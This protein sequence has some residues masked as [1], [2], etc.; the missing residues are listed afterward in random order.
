MPMRMRLEGSRK[1]GRSLPY[2]LV[3]PEV[4][5][6][7]CRAP[8]PSS[9]QPGSRSTCLEVTQQQEGVDVLAV[10]VVWEDEGPEFRHASSVALTSHLGAR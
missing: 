3:H 1:L 2:L 10:E 8:C 9:C 5:L 7:L 4:C 6:V